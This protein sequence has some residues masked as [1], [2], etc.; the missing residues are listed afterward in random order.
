MV[1]KEHTD[2]P[3]LCHSCHGQGT[4]TATCAC[5]CGASK[6]VCCDKCDGSGIERRASGITWKTPSDKSLFQVIFGDTWSTFEKM[7]KPS[8]N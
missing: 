4:V 1:S 2:G 5:G 8:V 3:K 7:C 6:T